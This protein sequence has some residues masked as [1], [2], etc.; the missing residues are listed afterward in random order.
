MTSRFVQIGSKFVNTNMIKQC[1]IFEK[2][3]LVKLNSYNLRVEWNHNKFSGNSFWMSSD[4]SNYTDYEFGFKAS[5]IYALHNI[6]NK[7]TVSDKYN[8][9]EIRTAVER[10]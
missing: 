2:T 8:I 9:H 6:V 3:N 1:Y 5:A 7:D 4:D 10:D